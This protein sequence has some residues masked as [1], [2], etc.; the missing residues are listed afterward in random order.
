MIIFLIN[1]FFWKI[2][3]NVCHKFPKTNEDV[4]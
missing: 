2:V 1:I 4:F 3:E